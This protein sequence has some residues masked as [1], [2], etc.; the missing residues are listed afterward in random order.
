M[1]IMEFITY[2]W[3]FCLTIGHMI[4]MSSSED[5]HGGSCYNRRKVKVTPYLTEQEKKQFWYELTDVERHELS[6]TTLDLHYNPP[7]EDK[8][9]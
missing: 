5:V 8:D 2:F 1:E 6:K 7:I 9:R 4:H 3:L